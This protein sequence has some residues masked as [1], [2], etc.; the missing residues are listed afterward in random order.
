MAWVQNPAGCKSINGMFFL[1]RK[2]SHLVNVAKLNFN[3]G[4]YV[5]VW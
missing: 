5:T 3:V 2:G 1:V 4:M